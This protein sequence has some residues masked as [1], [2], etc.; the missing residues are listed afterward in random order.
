MA[1]NSKL[2]AMKNKAAVIG[3][4]TVAFVYENRLD[5][6]GLYEPNK[7]STSR[8]KKAIITKTSS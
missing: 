3:L 8:K 7:T 4:I 1:I 2:A 5:L 6:L